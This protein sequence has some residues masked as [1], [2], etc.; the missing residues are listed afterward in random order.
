MPTLRVA[1]QLDWM[2]HELSQRVDEL[3]KLD[4]TRLLAVIGMHVEK[5]RQKQWFDR[6]VKNGRLKEG[7][8]VLLYTLKKHKRKI[9]MRGLGPYVLNTISPSGTMRL[10]TLE[11]EQMANFINGSRLKKYE[12]PLTEDMLQRMHQAR[13]RKE[14]QALLKQQA[15]EEARSRAAKNASSMYTQGS[16]SLA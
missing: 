5:R 13:T 6:H 12:E 14:A 7:D 16:S 9:K 10:E 1:K 11:G 3:E 8:L 2:G 4:E 15:Q